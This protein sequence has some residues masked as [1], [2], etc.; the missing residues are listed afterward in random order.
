VLSNVC[1]RTRSGPA[2]FTSAAS[3]L[4]FAGAW[5]VVD[6][7]LVGSETSCLAAADGALLS[8][9][10]AGACEAVAALSVTTGRAIP[11]ARRAA[12]LGMR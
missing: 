9:R 1:D 11:L 4:G 5:A 7:A 3:V 8:G 2:S 10:H 6:G 12:G